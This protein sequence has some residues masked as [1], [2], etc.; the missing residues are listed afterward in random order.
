MFRKDRIYF[1]N[2]LIANNWPPIKLLMLSIDG[3]DESECWE[4][5]IPH[6]DGDVEKMTKY[7]IDCASGHY[8]RWAV[9]KKKF[10]RRVVPLKECDKMI[11]IQYYTQIA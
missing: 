7:Q 4:I 6:A 2:E 10:V 1:C 9:N 3:E 8:L 11:S 5:E